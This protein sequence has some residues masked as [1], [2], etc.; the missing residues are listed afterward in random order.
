MDLYLCAVTISSITFID[1]IA[2]T[3]Y[4]ENIKKNNCITDELSLVQ[5][6]YHRVAQ[7]SIVNYGG[8]FD[9]TS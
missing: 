9:K 8:L 6:V 2:T 1:A 5:R 3:A 4:L 7:I